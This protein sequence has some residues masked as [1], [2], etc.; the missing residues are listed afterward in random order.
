MSMVGD[1]FGSLKWFTVY[2]LLL[3]AINLILLVWYAVPIQ[4]YVRWL[5]FL[6]SAGLLIAIASVLNGD[7]TILALSLYAVTAILFLCTVKKV[8]RPVRRIPMPKYRVLRI[9]LCLFGILSLALSLMLAGESRFNPVSHFSTLSYSQAFVQLNERLSREYPFGDWKKVDWTAMKDK[10]EPLFQQAEQ[11]KNKDLY[12]KTLRSYLYSFRDGHVKIM[13]EKLYDD[14]QAFKQEV[15][16]G[17]GLSTIQLDQGKVLVNL[18]LAGSPAEQSGIQ[19]GAE[20]ISWDGKEASEAYRASYW[21]ENPMATEGDQLQ[22]QGRFMARAPIGKEIQV[23]FKNK[24]D[25]EIKKATLK[26]YDDNYETLKKT[27]VKLNKTDAPVEGEVLSNGYGYVKIRYFLP[28]TTMSNPDKVLGDKLKE[29][30]AKQIKGL[31][32]DVRDNPGGSDDLVTAMAGYLVNKPKF[33]EYVSYYNRMAGKFEINA[34]ETRTIKPVEPYYGGKIAI[35]INQ[36]TGSSGEGLPI[37]AKGLPNVRIVGFTSTNGSF[38]VVTSPIQVEMPEG[39]VLQLPD[40]R[41]LNQEK[42]IQ[43]DSDDKGQGGAIPDIKIPLNEQTFEDK[44]VRGQDVE[45]NYAIQALE[46]MK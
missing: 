40:G 10:Y 5:D 6:P 33:Y 32:I 22:N 23:A 15:G 9:V 42:R 41:S 14:N 21:S 30:Q 38:G 3:F 24:G 34:N 29:F 37:A 44:Y 43:G 13:N 18:L 8:I 12:Y 26:A 39:Y 4:K 35:L 45:L 28:G 36:R 7:T 1:L 25:N 46:S 27:K 2:D 11:E 19:L 20:I 17:V 31:I 16:G